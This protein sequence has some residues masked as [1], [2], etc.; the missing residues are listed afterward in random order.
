MPTPSTMPC[1]LVMAAVLERQ[2]GR[3]DRARAVAATSRDRQVVAIARA[4]LDGERELV[5]ALAR[6]HLVDHPDS[7]IVGWIASD[8]D[9]RRASRRPDLTG[10]YTRVVLSISVLG[11]VEV[12]RAGELV[13]IPAGKTSELL[14]RLAL[15]AGVL[16]RTDRLVDDLWAV[17]AV[18]TSRNTLQSK[19]AKLRRALARSFPARQWRRRIHARRRSGRCR[20]ARRAAQHERRRRPC[21]MRATIVR[22]ADLCAATLTMFRGDLLV[23]A[24]DGDW[25]TPHRTRLDEARMKLIETGFSARLRSSVR[26]VM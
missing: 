21:S 23:G 16:V 24:G 2:P 19:V 8:A 14:V 3:L 1:S 22:A 20:R 12:R 17:D 25:V 11:P 4:H 18:R 5:D 7:L 6:D 9:R 13:P 10:P 26:P 15:D